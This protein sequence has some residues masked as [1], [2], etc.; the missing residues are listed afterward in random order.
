MRSGV[1]IPLSLLENQ[2]VSNTEIRKNPS[3]SKNEEGFFIFIVL[4]IRNLIL[5]AI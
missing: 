5:L 3:P 1:R 4:A 2:R